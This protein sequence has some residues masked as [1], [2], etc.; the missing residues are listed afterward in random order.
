VSL[1]LLQSHP[2]QDDP[3]IEVNVISDLR[4]FADDYTGAVIDEETAPDFRTR[5]Y[6]DTREKSV[7]MRK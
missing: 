3:L 1:L 4:S 2:T 7:H 6:F 5:V